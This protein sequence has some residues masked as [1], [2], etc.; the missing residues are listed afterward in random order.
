LFNKVNS[1]I[2]SSKRLY[3][4][5]KLLHKLTFPLLKSFSSNFRYNLR[6]E[7]FSTIRLEFGNSHTLV[8]F[9]NFLTQLQNFFYFNRD[10]FSK[11]S[12]PET[13]IS[14]EQPRFELTREDFIAFYRFGSQV[15]YYPYI[16][17]SDDFFTDSPYS[18]YEDI[19]FQSIFSPCLIDFYPL[20]LKKKG[21]KYAPLTATTPNLS[22]KKFKAVEAGLV[23]NLS[24][25]K[26][27]IRS[28]VENLFHI[29]EI[30]F[31]AQKILSPTIIKFFSRFLII[32]SGSATCNNFL[33]FSFSFVN[34]YFFFIQAIIF[35]LINLNLWLLRLQLFNI[36]NNG[37]NTSG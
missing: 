9:L 14:K 28:F 37:V 10:L 5:L 22:P 35:N 33:Q 6:R 12:S 29:Y 16:F 36:I 23:T 7:G 26:R 32:N 3:I 17:V 27:K 4:K 19:D 30:N 31:G 24:L 25:T 20:P 18:V 11:F 2:L 34:S 8:V 13:F 21:L 15:D 1:S